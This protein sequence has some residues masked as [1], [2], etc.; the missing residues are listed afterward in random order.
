MAHLAAQCSWL[1]SYIDI[2]VADHI[3][4]CTAQVVQHDPAYSHGCSFPS[5]AWMRIPMDERLLNYVCC[6]RLQS[7][8]VVI[9]TR[10]SPPLVAFVSLWLGLL[11]LQDGWLHQLGRLTFLRDAR[12]RASQKFYD[13]HEMC[14]NTSSTLVLPLVC[15]Q[16]DLGNP[17]T[18]MWMLT[19][20]CDWVEALSFLLFAVLRLRLSLQSSSGDT[21]VLMVTSM[22]RKLEMMDGYV[23]IVWGLRA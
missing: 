18:L 3:I 12:L 8:L 22:L 17:Q 6:S 9:R 5:P 20:F 16:H 4:G 23:N 15:Y 11:S 19:C 21:I 10:V 13:G 7:S 1:P 14:Q 2:G